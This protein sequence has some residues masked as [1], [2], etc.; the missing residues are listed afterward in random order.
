MDY[1]WLC[2]SALAAGAV[3]AVAGGGTLLTFP[4][5]ES[6]LA[7]EFTVLVAAK[8][9]NGTSTVALFPGSFGSVWGY[10]QQLAA[11]KHW[12]I[13]LTPPSI[14]GG[15]LGTWLVDDSFHFVV[16]WLILLA[17]VLFL[18]QP[19]IA[20]LMKH[21]ASA[22]REPSPRLLAGIVGVQFLI[23]VY[24][25]YFGAGI[26]ILMLSSLS[27]LGVKDIHHLN[28]LKTA[29]A[30]A[31]NLVSALIFIARGLVRWDYALAMAFAAIIGGYVG[32]RLSLR[33]RPI[34]VRWIV[35]AIGFGLAT[36][37]FMKPWLLSSGSES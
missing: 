4:V 33:L 35:I 37:Y 32:A 14:L 16:P 34:Y 24:G 21:Q 26:G 28:A 9:A 7:A 5:L 36:Y 13:W 27:F 22:L 1:V 12:I 10:R 25:G 29:L 19:T 20:R 23:G 8:L 17:A 6:V 11:C 30:F 31:M 18:L 3:N 15:A 2:L